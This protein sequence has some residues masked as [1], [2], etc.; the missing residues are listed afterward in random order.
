M[1]VCISSESC[2]R[3]ERQTPQNIYIF[4]IFRLTTAGS[5]HSTV[6]ADARDSEGK[7]ILRAER[8]ITWTALTARRRIY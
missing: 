4:S 7:T 3:S 5:D 6:T 2:I 1:C 8:I